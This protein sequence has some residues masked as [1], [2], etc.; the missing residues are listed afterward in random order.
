M[1]LEIAAEALGEKLKAAQKDLNFHR[2][3]VAH[4][5]EGVQKAQEALDKVQ[6]RYDQI[7]AEISFV[8]GING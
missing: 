7:C 2:S 5:Q 8:K 1:K 6:Q 3:D 4:L